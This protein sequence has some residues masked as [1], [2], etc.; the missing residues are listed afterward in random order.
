[1][2]LDQ[3]SITVGFSDIILNKCIVNNGAKGSPGTC[4]LLNSNISIFFFLFIP[5][6]YEESR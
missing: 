3:Q 1:M 4:N 6:H 2:P 5:T